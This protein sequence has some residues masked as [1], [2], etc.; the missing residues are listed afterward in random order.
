MTMTQVGNLIETKTEQPKLIAAD[1]EEMKWGPDEKD[2]GWGREFQKCN[3]K[4]VHNQFQMSFEP[5][6]AA[7][8]MRLQGEDKG[9]PLRD[10]L[11]LGT[12]RDNIKYPDRQYGPIKSLSDL[13]RDQR[14]Q[15]R[16]LHPEMESIRKCARKAC[17]TGCTRRCRIIP[18]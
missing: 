3:L 10:K 8:I 11:I 7:M 9:G 13:S 6:Q 15:V 18:T 16:G 1:I 14:S 17:T 5:D 12:H 2:K 4:Y